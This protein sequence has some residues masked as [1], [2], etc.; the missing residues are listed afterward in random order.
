MGKSRKIFKKR[1]SHPKCEIKNKIGSLGH[2]YVGT[3]PCGYKDVSI[4]L[5][6]Q[7]EVK[8]SY[9]G[10]TKSDH[11]FIMV[12]MHTVIEKTSNFETQLSP[13]LLM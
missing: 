8:G 7:V 9:S 13:S 4:K 5:I 6:E 2:N 3:S 10:N 11:T 1:H 12:Q